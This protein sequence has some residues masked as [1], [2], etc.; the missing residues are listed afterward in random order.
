MP[1]PEP[2][3][4]LGFDADAVVFAFTEHCDYMIQIFTPDFFAY[5]IEANILLETA[6]ETWPAFV[7]LARSVYT[8]I[9]GKYPALPVFLTIQA[10]FFAAAPQAQADS[11][12]LVMPFTDMIAASSYAFTSWADPDDVPADHYRRLAALAPEKPFA[13]AETGW[14]AED[15]TA[16]SPVTIPADTAAQRRFVERLLGDADSLDAR[17]VNWFFS[18]D[19]DDLWDSRLQYL[20]NAPLLRLWRDCGLRAGD[21]APRPALDAWRKRLATA[22]RP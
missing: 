20:D 14:P 9:K 17:F 4:T 6:P 22:R 19:F 16:P 12:A 11:L 3:D 21:G 13:W 18:R 10:E 15:V 2:W 8:A 5:A 1:L 7:T